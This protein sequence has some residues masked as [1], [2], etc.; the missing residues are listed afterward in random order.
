MQKELAWLGEEE[1]IERS[2]DDGEASV[3]SS[4]PPSSPLRSSA[5]SR[6][7]TAEAHRNAAVRFMNILEERME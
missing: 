5:H 6:D 1:A 2:G 4:L 7:G 3:F